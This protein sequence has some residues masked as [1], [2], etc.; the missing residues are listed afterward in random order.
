MTNEKTGWPDLPAAPVIET[1]L[2]AQFAPLKGLTSAHVGWFWK[3]CL[4]NKWEK[5][6]EAVALPDEFERF[7]P[8]SAASARFK[9]GPIGFP[10]R[11]Q[12]SWANEGRMMQ[13]Q[14]TRFHYNWNRIGGEYPR[15]RKV[16]EEFDH[17][18]E[19]FCRFVDQANLG[20]VVLNQW[21]LTY[22]DSIP[23]GSLWTTPADWHDVLPGLFSARGLPRHVHL[24]SFGGEWHFEIAPQLGRL[25]VSVQQARLG[26]NPTP[27]LLLQTTGRGAIGKEGVA[28]LA[29]GLELGHGAALELF[30][31]ITSDKA[32]NAWK[33]E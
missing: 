28:S 31:S 9:V 32:Q 30:F 4:D 21:E 3:Q 6:A 23:Q 2:G 14:A 27:T 12:F 26:D 17:H 29:E 33:G 7:G 15:Y 22:I 18:F 25:H 24:E 16:R 13:I 19:T 1:V 8:M 11:L 20:Q 10:P 5:V